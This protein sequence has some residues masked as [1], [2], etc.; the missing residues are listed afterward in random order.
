MAP[1]TLLYPLT[2]KQQTSRGA[3][4]GSQPLVRLP[5]LRFHAIRRLRTGYVDAGPHALVVM[6]SRLVPA[7]CFK[8]K[9]ALTVGIVHRALDLDRTEK[10]SNVVLTL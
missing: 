3:S 10:T 7:R 6:I 4:F 1:R 2:M 5:L 8:L 9:W